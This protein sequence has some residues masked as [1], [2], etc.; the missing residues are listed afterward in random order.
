MSK[1]ELSLSSISA[2][3]KRV[4]CALAFCLSHE[5]G[6]GTLLFLSIAPFIEGSQNIV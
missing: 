2:N 6:G 4:P 3:G 5:G 1:K